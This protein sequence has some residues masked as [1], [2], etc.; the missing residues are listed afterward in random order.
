M[1]NYDVASNAGGGLFTHFIE[2]VDL[3][4]R[5][6]VTWDTPSDKPN[7][8]WPQPVIELLRQWNGLDM[9]AEDK[10]ILREEMRLLLLKV[11]KV[12]ALQEVSVSV[13]LADRIR[14]DTEPLNKELWRRCS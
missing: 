8:R 4:G 13:R 12:R 5:E 14:R 2:K 7:K 1:G 10:G 11:P 6:S 9:P 3:S